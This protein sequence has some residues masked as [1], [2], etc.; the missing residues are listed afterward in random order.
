M[1]TAAQEV[2]WTSVV[3][4]AVGVSTLVST[5]VALSWQFVMWRWSGARI[6]PTL[7]PLTAY[8]IG[9]KPVPVISIQAANRGRGAC[10][11]TQWYLEDG[12]DKGMVILNHVIGSAELPV[13]LEGLHS[14]SWMVQQVPVVKA[15]REGGKDRVRPVVIIGSGKRFKGKWVAVS[16]FKEVDTATT[17]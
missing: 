6:V 1:S 17:A 8:Q 4:A 3:L 16:D 2:P 12:S 9:A 11:V 7:T 13:K 10:E 5:L 15:L 14:R